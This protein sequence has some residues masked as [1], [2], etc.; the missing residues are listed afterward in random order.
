MKSNRRQ[1]LKT[2]AQIGAV[3][4]IAPYTLTG[5]QSSSSSQSGGDSF[6]ASGDVSQTSVVLWAHPKAT[7]SVS[8]EVSTDPNFGTTAATANATVTAVN[9]PVKVQIT[10]L[11]AGTQY[12][13]R[14]VAG[15]L[16]GTGRFRTARALSGFGGLRF[17]VSGD[18]QGRLAPY[19]AIRNAAGADLDF[20][21]EHGDT[22]YSDYP[23]PDFNFP[24][25]ENLDDFRIKHNECYSARHGLNTWGDLRASTPIFA[26]IDDH[27]VRNNFAGGADPATDSRFSFTTESYINETDL[28]ENGMQAF[29]EYNPIADEFYGATG[30]PRTANKRKLYRFRTFGQDAAIFVLDARS[31]RDAPL[32]D[33]ANPLDPTELTAFI[34]QSFNPARTMLGAQQLTDFL[35]DLATAQAAGITWKFVLVPEP[36][37]NLPPFEASD[38]WDGYLAERSTILGFIDQQNITNVVFVAADIHGTIVNNLTYVNPVV[39]PTV[40]IP[41]DAFEMVTGSVAYGPPLGP[42]SIELA[43]AAG[44][45]TAAQK[46]SY[47]GLTNMDAKDLFFQNVANGFQTQLGYPT[48]GLAG[49]SINA[50]LL[51]GLWTRAHTFGWTQFEVDAATQVLTV[52][53]YGLDTYEETTAAQ[54]AGR[55]PFVVQQFAVTPT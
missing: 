13:Y 18:W 4:G 33:P 36:I 47:D 38:R 8:F 14:A 7:G 29:Q 51:Q 30:D 44:A 48:L 52:T 21:V 41:I 32:T 27:E 42:T 50:T 55:D 49:S 10:G 11:T 54:A 5:C 34:T 31:F 19:P 3:A 6:V 39:D 12:Y 17:G 9:I 25:A 35:T 22:I 15:G 20:F 53:T 45:V 28:Y 26:T 46:A 24:A 23:S 1:F 16:S 43:T 2:A 40:H 37:Q